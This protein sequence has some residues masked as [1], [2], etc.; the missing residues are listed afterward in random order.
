MKK[1]VTI[2]LLAALVVP[3][4]ANVTVALVPL[5]QNVGPG[6]TVTISANLTTDTAFVMSSFTANGFGYD[7]AVFDQTV[8]IVVTKGALLNEGWSFTPGPGTVVGDDFE[9]WFTGYQSITAGTTELFQITLKVRDTAPLGLS[10]LTWV[11]PTWA[12]S[13]FFTYSDGVMNEFDASGT[14][15]ASIN[16]V[17]PVPGAILLGGIGVSLVGWMKRRRSL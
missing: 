3:A 11:G 6:G 16:V 2:L 8:P 10:E 1:L 7:W 17:V 9:D 13:T 5:T 12:P 15:G 14:S 4:M